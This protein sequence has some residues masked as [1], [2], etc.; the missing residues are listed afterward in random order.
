MEILE[1]EQGSR[2]WIEAR[3]G[4]VTASKF[5][6]V[7]AKTP[8]GK[9]PGVTRYKYMTKLITEIDEQRQVVS[10]HDK[11]M[12]AGTDKEAGAREWYELIT[13]NSVEEVGFIKLD[14]HVGCSPDGLVGED[15][16]VE[17]KCPL[18]TTHRD[19]L[20]GKQSL[21][22]TYWKQIQ[23]QMYVT[24]R[25]WCEI[26]SFRPENKKHPHILHR[27]KRD[28]EFIHELKI[29]L[30]MFIKD[31]KKRIEKTDKSEF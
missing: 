8:S 31:M 19:Y 23:G 3:L 28:E 21:V 17:L 7:M 2:G 6:D 29:E 11:N 9:S 13:G 1:F 18:G 5:S 30:V 15:G 12:E 27:V 14:D 4:M 20:E 24:G 26:M 25:K 22:K 16:L 10:Y